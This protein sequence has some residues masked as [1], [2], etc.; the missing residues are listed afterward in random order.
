MVGTKLPDEIGQRTVISDDLTTSTGVVDRR[1]D[2]AAMPDDAGITEQ[3]KHVRLTEVS[4]ALDIE[5]GECS[6]KI[7]AFSQNREPTQTRL[8]TLKADL[9]E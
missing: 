3:S 4:D 5:V 6:P 9:L 7:L 2:L 1:L 8:K